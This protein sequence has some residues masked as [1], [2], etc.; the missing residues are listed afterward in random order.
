MLTINVNSATLPTQLPAYQM[1]TTKLSTMHFAMVGL[2]NK[3]VWFV[4]RSISL[5]YYINM[6]VERG[7]VWNQCLVSSVLVCLYAVTKGS[8]SDFGT[9]FSSPPRLGYVESFC[10]LWLLQ[11]LIM[12]EPFVGLRFTATFLWYILRHQWNVLYVDAC[13]MYQNTY[14][15][16]CLYCHINNAILLELPPAGSVQP[17]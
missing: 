4:G 14:F 17:F 15:H 12:R 6:N 11:R 10:R 7:N 13:N 2:D 8:Q 5:T 9:L 16:V 3:N 1:L